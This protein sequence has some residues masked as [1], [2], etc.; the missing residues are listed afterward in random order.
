MTTAQARRALLADRES[1]LCLLARV[2]PVPTNGHGPGD[3]VDRILADERTAQALGN[4]ERWTA[5]LAAIEAALKKIDAGT[6]GRCETCS[7]AIGA[8]RLRAL[9]LAERCVECQGQI[10]RLLAGEGD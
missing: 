9:P 1:L 2:E 10:E 3:E 4:R 5:K 8:G 7:G 6:W